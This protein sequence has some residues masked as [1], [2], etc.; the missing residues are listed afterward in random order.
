MIKPCFWLAKLTDWLLRPSV[1]AS[2]A[3]FCL[4][5]TA[6]TSQTYP[7]TSPT[8]WKFTLYKLTMKSS[9]WRSQIP[10]VDSSHLELEHVELPQTDTWRKIWILCWNCDNFPR[11]WFHWLIY[12]VL[13]WS[14]G[15]IFLALHIYI[16]FCEIETNRIS[17]SKQRYKRCKIKLWNLETN[18]F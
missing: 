1:W 3:S 9:S 12:L 7:P 13:V 11:G 14:E 5:K 10:N 18:N 16:L 17:W 8:A 2:T 15:V 4:N 6:K